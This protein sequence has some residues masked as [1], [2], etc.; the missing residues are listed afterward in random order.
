MTVRIRHRDIPKH[1]LI[2]LECEITSA[3]DPTHIGKKGVIVTDVVPSS[4]AARAG[5][6]QGILIQ[7]VNR[8]Q[9]SSV[10]DFLEAIKTGKG[11]TNLLLITEGRY[12]RYIPL[13]FED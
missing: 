6:K 8:N 12:S 4:K 5:L 9:I 2:G 11:V 7:Q 10:K 13:S 3:T 1:E